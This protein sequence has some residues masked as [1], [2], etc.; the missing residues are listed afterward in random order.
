MTRGGADGAGA[1][2]HLDRI[3]AGVDQRPR[4]LGR[5]DVACHHLGVIAEGLDVRHGARYGL[6]VAV[7]R[8]D[9]DEVAFGAEQCL[10]PRQAFRADAGCGPGAEPALRV[11]AGVGKGLCPFDVL[12]RD[13]ADAAIG[14]VDHHEL[15]DPMPVEE[16]LRR[17]AGPRP[18]AP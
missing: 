4:A 1:D 16:P 10:G 7:R 14:V 12:D 3:G 9:D 6:A 2:A 18:R 11:L 5:G 13:E 17:V 15:L 8:V